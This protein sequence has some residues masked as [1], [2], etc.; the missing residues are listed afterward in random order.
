MPTA[1]VASDPD[2][3]ARR[4]RT[5][6]L[7]ALPTETVYGLGANA[8]SEVAVSR[9]FAAKNRP[10]FDPLILHQADAAAILLY[11]RS[12]PP[13]AYELAAACWPGT[14]YSDT[15]PPGGRSRSGHRRA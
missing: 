10:A 7:V 14:P 9:I 3:A 12:V 13:P 1:P 5:G 6:Q 11:A 4:L 8:L 2:E 15:A